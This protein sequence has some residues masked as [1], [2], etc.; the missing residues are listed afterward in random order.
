[1]PE[2]QLLGMLRQEDHKLLLFCAIWDVAKKF[3]FS[4]FGDF[5]ILLVKYRLLKPSSKE[6]Q[7]KILKE[8]IIKRIPI[9]INIELFSNFKIL[10]LGINIVVDRLLTSRTT[11]KL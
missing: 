10:V 1:M 7:R 8:S 4:D 6:S 5:C 9:R 2:S 3:H 11:K